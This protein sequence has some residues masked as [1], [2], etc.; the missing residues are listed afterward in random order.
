MWLQKTSLVFVSGTPSP[1]EFSIA[2][3]R[4]SERKSFGTGQVMHQSLICFGV[5]WGYLSG[6]I[7]GIH[8]KIEG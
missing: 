7:L 2:H 1:K 5:E 6:A 4:G 8:L 3:Y